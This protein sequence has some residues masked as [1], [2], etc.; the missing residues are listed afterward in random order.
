MKKLICLLCLALFLP[1]ASLAQSDALPDPGKSFFSAG[2]L[3]A[4]GVE[5]DGVRYDVYGYAFEKKASHSLTEATSVYQVKAKQA[6]FTW[7]ALKEASTYEGLTSGDLWYAVSRDGLTALLCVSGSYFGASCTAALYVP[8][9][10]P[11]TLAESVGSRSHFQND[12]F[13][14]ADD[15]WTPDGGASVTTCT[16]CHGSGRCSLCDG[17]GIYT[18]PYTGSRKDCSCDNGVCSVC[19]GRGTWGE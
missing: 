6:G 19:D 2:E 12:V 5:A 13:V 14:D 11:F 9:G 1:V 8:E 3:L 17:T 7:E 10:M 16:S 4:Q 15:L 18:N